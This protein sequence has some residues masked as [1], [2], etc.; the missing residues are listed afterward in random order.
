MGTV[1][2]GWET[3]S[4]HAGRIPRQAGARFGPFFVR[5]EAWVERALERAT[6][7]PFRAAFLLIVL[8]L[9]LFSPGFFSRPPVDRTE[10]R[11]AITAQ[12][13]IETG[14]WFVVREGTRPKFERPVGI[15]WLQS[16]SAKLFGP[17][18]LDA[19]WAYRIPSLLGAILSVVFLYLGSRALVGETTAFFASVLLAHS[20]FLAVEAR[21]ALPQSVA[22]AASVLAQTSLARLYVLREALTNAQRR[23]TG[24]LFWGAIGVG[25]LV[26][27]LIVP[28][29]AVL[30]LAALYAKDRNLCLLKG[31]SNVLGPLLALA[32]AAPW[33]ASVVLTSA[34]V[35]SDRHS[36][37]RWI[38]LL[39]DSQVM[40]HKAFWGSFVL[41]AWL[42]ILPAILLTFPT[43]Q[44]IW[45]ERRVPLVAFLI[46]WAV[47]YLVLFELLSDK[48]PLYM[49]QYVAPA[50]ALAFALLVTRNPVTGD[51]P[52]IPLPRWTRVAWML[53]AACMAL[54]PIGLHLWVGEP[55]GFL[56]VAASAAILLLFAATIWAWPHCRPLTST[57]FS[58]A[59]CAVA[60]WLVM[61][62]LMPA[63]SMVWPS[64]RLEEVRDALQPCFPQPVAI[65]GYSEPSATFLMGADIVTGRPAVVAQHLRENP[66]SLA[67]ITHDVLPDFEK[68]FEGSNAAPARVACVRGWNT[69]TSKGGQFS[70]F[71]MEPVPAEPTCVVPARYR[72][73]AE[74]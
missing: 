25:V 57:T 10:V 51:P 67:F 58:L 9:A 63:E 64:V 56:M 73:A 37:L 8:C 38:S 3:D 21:L 36:T 65:A 27:S 43:A 24:L 60:Y 72:C 7:S 71:A 4:P 34:E 16:L 26:N 23:R 6:K 30:T 49:L 13:M 52:N 50:I 55:V 69:F 48:P 66:R 54:I 62:M 35:S 14:D 2:Q 41:M 39:I 46:A 45:R 74:D 22:L 5:Y 61:A 1:A 12:T 33:V 68:E 42:G 53:L 32:L 29:V 15:V 19:I 11:Y 17:P 44:L 70:V 47:P 20:I 31:A 40:H 18:G 28:V 59:G